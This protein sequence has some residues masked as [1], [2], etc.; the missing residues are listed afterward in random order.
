M[1]QYFAYFYVSACSKIKEL[2]ETF[3]E[4]QEKINPKPGKLIEPVE[5]PDQ[6]C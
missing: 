3:S 5:I 4:L 1:L 6:F 2:N